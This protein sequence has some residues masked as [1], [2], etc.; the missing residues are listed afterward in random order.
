[1][2]KDEAIIEIGKTAVLLRKAIVGG[3]IT[4]VI[5]TL[6]YFVLKFELLG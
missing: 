6:I 2:K 1:M 4:S 5:L 3:F